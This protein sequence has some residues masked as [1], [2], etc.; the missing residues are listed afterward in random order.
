M[1]I[2]LKCIIADCRIYYCCSLPAAPGG[3]PL[4]RVYSL[5]RI[6]ISRRGTAGPGR[7]NNN[8]RARAQRGRPPPPAGIISRN[9]ITGAYLA[10]EVIFIP[11]VLSRNLPELALFIASYPPLSGYFSASASR[12]RSPLVLPPLSSPSRPSSRC[13]PE[14]CEV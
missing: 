11:F 10:I 8:A 1:L 6:I 4:F 2:M 5:A 14:S 13:K 12:G 7:S 3:P 9:E